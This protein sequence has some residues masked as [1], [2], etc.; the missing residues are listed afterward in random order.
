M[1]DVPHDTSHNP[2]VARTLFRIDRV[3]YFLR[4]KRTYWHGHLCFPHFK[5]GKFSHGSAV[6]S[7]FP[8]WVHRF[9]CKLYNLRPFFLARLF[10]RV[11]NR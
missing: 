3:I 4:G 5:D 11:L 2:Y 6:R 9:A 7:H 1:S 8:D 10:R